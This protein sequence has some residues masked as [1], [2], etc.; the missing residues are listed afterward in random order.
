MYYY[1]IVIATMPLAYI[2][3]LLG[4]SSIAGKILLDKQTKNHTNN[5]YNK[6]K[7]SLSVC[8]EGSR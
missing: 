7:G 2:V 1:T 8:T 5:P 4:N 6:I 3:L